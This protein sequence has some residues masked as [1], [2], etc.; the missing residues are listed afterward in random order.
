[1]DD[2]LKGKLELLDK[3][4]RNLTDIYLDISEDMINCEPGKDLIYQ[5]GI[6]DGYRQCIRELINMQTQLRVVGEV[7]DGKE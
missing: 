3:S 7:I 5:K 1:M 6:Q 2:I 4:I